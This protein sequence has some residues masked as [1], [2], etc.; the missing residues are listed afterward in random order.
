MPSLKE[1]ISNLPEP[2][3]LVFQNKLMNHLYDRVWCEKHGLDYNNLPIQDVQLAELETYR[4]IT[5][6]N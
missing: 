5:S 3:Q 4:E 6:V 2:K 1:M